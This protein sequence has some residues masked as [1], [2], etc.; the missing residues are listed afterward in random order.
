MFDAPPEIQILKG[1]YYIQGVLAIHGYL[2]ERK[3]R[4]LQNRELRGMI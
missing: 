1:L 3:I 4:E 2:G